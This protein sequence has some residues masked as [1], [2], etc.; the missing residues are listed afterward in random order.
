MPEISFRKLWILWAIA[1]P[2]SRMPARIKPCFAEIIFEN[3][4]GHAFYF[5][6]ATSELS[7]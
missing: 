7:I 1:V 3:F 6:A 5:L 2:L 4:K